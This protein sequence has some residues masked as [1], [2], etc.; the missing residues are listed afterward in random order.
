MGDPETG[1]APSLR[2]FFRKLWSRALPVNPLESQ[3]FRSGI[4]AEGCGASE[5][6]LLRFACLKI[7]FH[8][9]P[10]TR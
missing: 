4:A 7:Y 1:Q 8:C 9:A 3:F 10:P 2:E 5:E 6:S